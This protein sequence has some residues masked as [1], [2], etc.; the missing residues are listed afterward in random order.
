MNNHVPALNQTYRFED[1]KIIFEDGVTYSINEAVM[2]A[3]DRLTDEDIQA[4]HLVKRIF[5]GEIEVPYRD[6]IAVTVREPVSPDVGVDCNPP[7]GAN[8]NSPIRSLSDIASEFGEPP[9]LNGGIQ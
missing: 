3:R 8:C 1:G 9:L 5:G 4:I 7:V 2:M 6:R